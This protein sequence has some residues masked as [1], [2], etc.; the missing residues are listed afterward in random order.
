M[1]SQLQLDGVAAEDPQQGLGRQGTAPRHGLACTTVY[2]YV[3]VYAYVYVYVY[4]LRI[5]GFVSYDAA[6]KGKVKKPCF[7]LR[8]SVA[9]VEL[10]AK[11]I[12]QHW[13]G[14]QGYF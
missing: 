5:A 11:N 8:Q 12:K 9:Q 3:Y 4:V 1:L 14:Q 6:L 13:V 10:L 2:V 7:S